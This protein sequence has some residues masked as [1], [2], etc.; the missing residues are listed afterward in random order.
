MSYR[1]EVQECDGRWYADMPELSNV[2]ASGA[3]RA[4]AIRRVELRALEKLE[5][6]AQH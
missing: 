6:K 5:E 2:M 3:T 4:E 1:I